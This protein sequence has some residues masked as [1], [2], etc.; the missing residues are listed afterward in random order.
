M[1]FI[2]MRVQQR[3]RWNSATHQKASAEKKKKD[4]SRFSL[5]SSASASAPRSLSVS[6][7]SSFARLKDRLINLERDNLFLVFGSD[8]L[9]GK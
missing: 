8:V 7:P 6:S 9:R 2:A 4:I 3:R 5:R 1:R